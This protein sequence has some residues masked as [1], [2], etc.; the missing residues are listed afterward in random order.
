MPKISVIVPAYN[1]ELYIGKCIDTLAKQTLE[2]LEIIIV[3]DGSTDRTEEVIRKKIERYSD[4]NIVLFNKENGGQSD[5]RNFGMDKATGDYI[6]FVDGDDYVE[7]DMFEEMYKK[8]EEYPYDIVTCDV[9]CIYP[10]KNVEIKSGIFSDKHEMEVQDRK[11]LILS[12]YTVVWNKIYKRELLAK[13][14]YFAKGIWYEDVLFLY[15]VFPYV[16]S[17]GVVN[18]KLYNYMQR[19]NSVTYTYSDKLYDINKSLKLLVNYFEEQGL[20]A[21]YDDILEYVYVRYMYATFIKRLAKAK[22]RERFNAGVDFAIK[23]VNEMY[24][25]YK[26][27]RFLRSRGGKNLY[28]RYFNKVLSKIIYVVEKNRMN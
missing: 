19:I 25:N 24:P 22:D 2:D 14:K 28:L 6:A 17:V 16:N 15:K 11:E 12:S 27:N 1:I 8:V 3:N 10:N 18:K 4:K 20:K 5:A 23:D 7:L 21:E 13:D 9:N 26:Q